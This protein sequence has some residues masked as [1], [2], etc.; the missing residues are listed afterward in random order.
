MTICNNDA[1][2]TLVTHSTVLSTSSRTHLSN[3]RKNLS[4]TS[5]ISG[6]TTN[7]H[8]PAGLRRAVGWGGTGSG[9]WCHI[10]EGPFNYAESQKII[11]KVLPGGESN[12]GYSKD[13]HFSELARTRRAGEEIF[14]AT[15][16]R[17][18]PNL[19]SMSFTSVH[20]RL[21]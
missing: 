3:E 6:C 17:G 12:P 1:G 18:G 14:S 9:V 20:S 16:L 10:Y 4:N 21:Y 15:S 7:E 11:I 13:D 19:M 2:V 5:T 8:G